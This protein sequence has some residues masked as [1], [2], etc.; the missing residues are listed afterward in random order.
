M[1]ISDIQRL[2]AAAG[3][4]KGPIDNVPNDAMHNAASKIVDKHLGS[5]AASWPQTRRAVGAGQLVLKFAGYDPG[6]I[7]GYSGRYTLAAL[8]AFDGD[9]NPHDEAEFPVQSD[10]SKFYGEPGAAVQ[11]QLRLYDL[12]LTMR[13]DWDLSKSV[14]R[15]Q[16]HE[17]CGPSGVAIIKDTIA[18]Y[19]EKRWRELGLDRHAGTYVHRV[20]RGGSKWSMHAY[21]CAWDFYAGPNGLSVRKPKALFSGAAYVPFFNIVEGH[22]WLSLGRTADMDWMHIQATRN[23]K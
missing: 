9:V 17:K 14:Q 19:G 10:A 23:L 1:K 5:V 4:Y 15:V 20:M 2:L 22:G 11:Q 16:L 18:H 12:P 8:A 3:Y 13:L 21:G 6:T 7:D